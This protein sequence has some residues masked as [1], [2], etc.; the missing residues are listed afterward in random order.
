MI[1]GIIYVIVGFIEFVLAFRLLFRLF[2]ANPGNG[3][4]SWIYDIS[5]PLVA[6]FAGIFG[7]PPIVE[8]A[9]V[10]GV[11]ELG[12]LVALIVYGLIGGFIVRLLSSRG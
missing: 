9:A 2:G 3:F 6:P 10:R 5:A 4:V 8:G 12:T 11:F 1:A 7:Q